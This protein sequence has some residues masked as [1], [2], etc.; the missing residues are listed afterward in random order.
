MHDILRLYFAEKTVRFTDWSKPNPETGVVYFDAPIEIGD[1]TET[2]V[3]LHGECVIDRPDC[4]VGFEL[5][6]QKQPGR[7]SVPIE[8]LDWRSLEGGHSNVRAPRPW[9]GKRTSWT[10]V[11][12]FTMNWSRSEKR[13]RGGVLKAA[14][15]LYKELDTFED[16]RREAGKRLR[17]KNI[18]VVT[19]PE[20]VYNLFGGMR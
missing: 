9:T 15:D 20:W 7:R 2:G 6:I 18:H 1:V 13:I 11:H 16:V 5:R 19:R 3:V 14:R 12:A 17:I 4:N 8:R 10:H